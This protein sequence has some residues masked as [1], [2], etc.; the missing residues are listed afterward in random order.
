MTDEAPVTEPIKRLWRVGLL[1][2]DLAG[3]RLRRGG[4][5]APLARQKVVAR[6]GEL[7]GL[8][9]K[10]GQLLALSGADGP[11]AFAPLTE[12]PSPMPWEKVAPLLSSRLGRPWSECFLGIEPTGIAASLGQVHRGILHDGRLVAVKIQYPDSAANV[13]TDLGALGWLTLPFGGLRR[14]FDMESYRREIG[15]ML[16][17]E[18]DYR[19]EAE[20][21]C[22]FGVL[23]QGCDA[24]EV[25]KVIDALS[26]EHV[27]TM[28]W[29]DGE[30][31]EGVRTWPEDDRRRAAEA[32]LRVFLT[33]LLHW[34]LLH[35]DPHPGN[36]R[37]LRDG[38][39][40]RVGLLDFGAVVAVE[41]D[42]VR[43][44]V[45]L[46]EHARNA[47]GPPPLTPP[48]Q[49]G[50]L[51]TGLSSKNSPPWEGGVRGG[52]GYGPVAILADYAALG[53]SRDLL[54]PL[55][56]RLPALNRLLFEPFVTD[57]PFSLETWHLGERAE[58]ILGDLRWNFRYAGPADLIFVVRAYMGLLRYMR[59]LNVAIDWAETWRTLAQPDPAPVLVRTPAEETP[60]MLSQRLRVAVWD[61][62]EARVNLTFKPILAASLPDLIPDDLVAKLQERSV[63]VQ[64]I[65]DEAVANQFA[66][67][68]LFQMSEGT[69]LVRVWL[70]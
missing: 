70:E 10:I 49:G 51:R 67:G 24:V 17:R 40:V 28:T 20:A 13:E 30:N 2:R 4:R 6:L 29:L 57:G 66:P 33:S 48:S 44:F 5:S 34:R 26:N 1:A 62:G 59:V 9:Q 64:R 27:L 8:P 25:P 16:H 63:D 56:D 23:A 15:G 53:F 3:A 11:S 7:H 52:G 22:R 42:R 50:E 32:L 45:R 35:A 21:L 36:Y 18:L 37:F 43:A 58:Q 14:R 60:V 65:A 12:A 19:Q 55:A 39:G 54:E 31:V 47:Q 41:E 69:K 68:E 38:E 46:V 61:A